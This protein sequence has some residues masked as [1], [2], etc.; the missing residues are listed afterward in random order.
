[1]LFHKVKVTDGASV[2]YPEIKPDQI[3][4]LYSLTLGGY[5]V[6]VYNNIVLQRDILYSVLSLS[7]SDSPFKYKC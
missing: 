2:L 1:M 6:M 5:L 7:P 4:G 3:V